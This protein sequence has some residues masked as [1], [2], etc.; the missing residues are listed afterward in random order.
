MNQILKI[1]M[2]IQSKLIIISMILI[3]VP[4]IILGQNTYKKSV[5]V[6]GK[7]LG[8]SSLAYIKQLEISIRNELK[9]VE[10]V[11]AFMSEDSIFQKNE[12]LEYISDEMIYHFKKLKENNPNILNIYFVKTNGTIYDY[13]SYSD[14]NHYDLT[15][16]NWY[17]EAVKKKAMIWA[18]PYEDLDTHQYVVSLATPIYDGNSQLLG[19][20]GADVSMETI[21]KMMKHV[22][23]GHEG[24]AFILEETDKVITHK[25]KDLV[26]K[27]FPSKEVIDAI[28]KNK[29]GVVH[30]L[31]KENNKKYKKFAVYTK[32]EELNWTILGGMYIDEIQDQTSVILDYIL[33]IGG[34]SLFCAIFIAYVF[35]NRMSKA[36]KLLVNSM[37][38]VRDGDLNIYIQNNRKDEIGLLNENFNNMVQK[39]KDLTKKI[40]DVSIEVTSSSQN[41]VATS[42]ITSVS[43]E[44][45]ASASEIIAQGASE[46][47]SEAEKA[48]HLTMNLAEVFQKLIKNME[49]IEISSEEAILRGQEGIEAVIELEE[50]TNV[51]QE[52]IN[53]IEKAVIDL[54]GRIKT[55]GKILETMDSISEQTNLLALNASIEAAR[56]GE[57]GKG[58]AVVAEEIRKLAEESKNSSNGIK[59]IIMSIQ[60]ESEYTVNTMKEVKTTTLAQKEGVDK[61]NES[62]QKIDGSI[63]EVTKDIEN[64]QRI[65]GKLDG[66]KDEIVRA[67]ENISAISQ[68]TASS[69][70]EV[71]A[72]IE[73]QTMAMKEIATAT[74]ELDELAIRLNAELLKFKI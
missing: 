40:Q 51:T 17:K 59:N 9:G 52:E 71:S 8:R 46:Q 35:S 3:A 22:K 23:I 74:D 6:T 24:Y 38:K 48:A 64:I 63:Q 28:K 42:E 1:R 19:V 43:L 53:E 15:Q 50:K 54:D 31:W 2:S 67:I 56:A 32:L 58:F 26:G 10:Q 61:V 55:I 16:R 21:N 69:S 30:Y 72:S 14:K 18:Q 65:I 49:P 57:S 37:Q 33:W 41:L 4:L 34:I 66:Q 60:S 36:I 70:E 5:E 7:E 11:L 62:F 25:N 29:E 45:V 12:D 20:L 44:Q 39:L 27:I 73:Q 47:A 13:P 68:E